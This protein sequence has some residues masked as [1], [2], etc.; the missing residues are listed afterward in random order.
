MPYRYRMHWYTDPGTPLGAGRPLVA[1]TPDEAIA[2]ATALW[3]EG[4]YATARG[5]CV[6][7]SDEGT[8]LWRCKREPSPSRL[9][10]LRSGR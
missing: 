4:V 6:A 9:G 2:Q 5:Y 1:R 3:E 8:I 10:P 7:D